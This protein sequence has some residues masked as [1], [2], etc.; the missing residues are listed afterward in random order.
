MCDTGDLM[1]VCRHDAIICVTRL[2]C[3]C[4]VTHSAHVFVTRLQLLIWGGYNK[5]EC[6]LQKRPV[7][8][9]SLLI[10]ATPHPSA[11]SG[12]SRAP[13]RSTRRRR[14]NRFSISRACVMAYIQISHG[15]WMWQS[16]PWRSCFTRMYE[17][18]MYEACHIHK[19]VA[20][21][22][23]SWVMSN[24]CT[25]H[26]T[27][28]NKSRHEYH[29]VTS[30]MTWHVMSHMTWW[31]TSHITSVA[32]TF[33]CGPWL[34]CTRGMTHSDMCHDSYLWHDSFGHVT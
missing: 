15:K 3:M 9:R 14:Q 30:H 2:K 6:I 23:F 17:S 1:R 20:A 4:D 16:N 8:L 29:G 27:H 5:R 11:R 28:V 7:I 24:T 19:G 26:V 32:A 10:I 25:R 21:H 13:K 34:L 22:V 33:P 12:E 18:R 31:V